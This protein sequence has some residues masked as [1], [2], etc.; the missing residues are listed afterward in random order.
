MTAAF[1]KIEKQCKND[2]K[3]LETKKDTALYY[4]SCAYP[5]VLFAMYDNKNYAPIIWKKIKPA[6]SKPFKYIENDY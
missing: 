3:K 2:F 4:L 6:Y 5:H 1:E